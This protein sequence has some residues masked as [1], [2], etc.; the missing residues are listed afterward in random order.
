MKKC[1]LLYQNQS[2]LWKSF[3][4][5]MWFLKKKKHINSKDIVVPKIAMQSWQ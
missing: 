4:S 3:Y 2:K 5:F 1:S